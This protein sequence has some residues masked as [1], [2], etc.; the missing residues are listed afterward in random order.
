MTP[1]I[2]DFPF[3][4]NEQEFVLPM[5]GCYK[6]ETWGAQGGFHFGFGIGEPYTGLGEGGYGVYSVGV[7]CAPK[8]QILYVYVGGKGDNESYT[9]VSGGWNGGGSS[10]TTYHTYHPTGGGATDVSLVKSSV[11]EDSSKRWVRTEASYKS[12]IIVAGGGGG[13]CNQGKPEGKGRGGNGGGY[14]GNQ[15]EAGYRDVGL[16]NGGTQTSAGVITNQYCST[17]GFGYGSG[18]KQALDGACGGGGWWGG[19][20]ANDGGG[21]GGSGYIGGVTSHLKVKKRMVC[22]NCQT[23][24]EEN[25]FTQSVSQAFFE[26]VPGAGKQGDG[27]ARISLL[28]NPTCH[29]PRYNLKHILF[30]CNIFVS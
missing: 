4:R 5:D 27:F 10:T 12:R 13:G 21:G 6:I 11:T 18:T 1:R 2:Y 3:T 19:N 24:N 23:S 26:P 9:S 29:V 22:V 16:A 28:S 25:T 7:Y 20:E 15:G 17:G 8:G 30:F 14:I